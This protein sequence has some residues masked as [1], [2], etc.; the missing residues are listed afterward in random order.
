MSHLRLHLVEEA[1]ESLAEEVSQRF[2]KRCA[3]PGR[4]KRFRLRRAVHW[5]QVV[6]GHDLANA[7]IILQ[8]QC[9]DLRV[10][11]S[12]T[13]Y[14]AAP[15]SGSQQLD[16]SQVFEIIYLDMQVVGESA[17]TPLGKFYR[18]YWIHA[19]KLISRSLCML[20]LLSKHKKPVHLFMD[21]SSQEL[22]G[23]VNVLGTECEDRVAMRD[24]SFF[25]LYFAGIAP[26]V[27]PV[28]LEETQ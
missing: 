26:F 23:V 15:L 17:A 3:V 13:F 16:Q 9:V 4:D 27:E 28:A 21:V 6:P 12:N 10:V 5:D 20:K 25:D 24:C 8:D 7:L 18:Q 1:S 14:N 19:T 11:G 22:P 2:A